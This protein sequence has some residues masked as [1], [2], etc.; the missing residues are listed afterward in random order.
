[1][2]NNSYWPCVINNYFWPQLLGK[3]QP[4]QELWWR[5]TW[6][7]SVLKGS[8]SSQPPLKRM[9]IPLRFRLTSFPLAFWCVNFESVGLS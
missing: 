9:L 2:T 6:N 8:A 1:M 4:L 3:E 7:C 5:A